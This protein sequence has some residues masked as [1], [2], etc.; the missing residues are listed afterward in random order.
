MKLAFYYHIP[1]VPNEHDLMTP[2]YLGVFIDSLASE[3]EHL[4][5]VMH[6]GPPSFTEADYTIKASNITW[7]NL[8]LKTPAW[9]RALFYKKILQQ[10]LD[11]I[12]DC[13]IMLV[14][15]PSPLAP[16]FKKYLHHTKLV[17]MIVGDYGEGLVN[18]K[19]GGLRQKLIKQFLKYN[20]WLFEKEIRKTDVVVNSPM[21]FKKYQP[22]AKSTHQIRT[23]T[24]ST[25]D[26][27]QREDTCKSDIIQLLFTGRID[28]QKGL[29]ELVEATA[30]LRQK[31]FNVCCNIVGWESDKAKPVEAALL[32]KAKELGIDGHLIF[33]GRKSVG[34]DLN[35][36]YQMGDLYI[37]PS[38]H[39]GFPRTIW[40]AMANSLPVI[41]T[42][43]GAIPE[44]LTNEKNALLI[45]PKKPEGIFEAVEKI[46][47]DTT[48]RKKMIAEGL[49][50]AKEN[51]LEF[52]T[53]YLIKTLNDVANN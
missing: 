35:A 28:P 29:F 2:S 3:V 10:K 32:A 5:L 13:E 21:L 43:V 26:F 17:Y 31:G 20:I 51:T 11:A 50:L 8:G 40:E 15:S 19:K 18:M 12:R 14:R 45:E 47:Q 25:N 34:P 22:F 44:Y 37:I 42:R 30:Q 9:H 4:Y 52:Q 36:M 39:E 7:V 53:K 16:Y 41:A 27:F 33:H 23:T 48:L 24:L 6:E 46:L 1:I 49:Q 38:Y